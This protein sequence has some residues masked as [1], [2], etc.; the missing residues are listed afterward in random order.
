MTKRKT[1]PSFNRDTDYLFNKDTGDRI[2]EYEAQGLTIIQCDNIH[3]WIRKNFGNASECTHC[4]TT[5]SKRYEW[6]L[7]HGKKYERNIDNFMPLCSKCHRNYDKTPLSQVTLLRHIAANKVPREKFFEKIRKGCTLK[8]GDIFLSFKSIR[9]CCNFF[10]FK[11]Q[12]G[13]F[14]KDKS[15]YKGYL[16]ERL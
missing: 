13:L 2:R 11:R 14:K 10:G 4:K 8:K 3:K 5:T 7:I 9:E 6:A 16:F 15:F 12:G 1:P